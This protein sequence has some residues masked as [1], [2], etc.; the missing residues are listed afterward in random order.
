MPDHAP[1]FFGC[2]R[3]INGYGHGHYLFGP[4]GRS[5]YGRGP[6]RQPWGDRIDGTL[7]PKTTTAQGAAALYHKDG[8]TALAIHDYTGD[9]RPGS[10]SVFF[11]PTDLTFHAALAAAEEHFP[12]LAR[13]IGRIFLVEDP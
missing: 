8:W 13:R 9:H 6:L 10:N 1:L 4:D 11:F 12:D 2:M 5:L 3:P 7:T